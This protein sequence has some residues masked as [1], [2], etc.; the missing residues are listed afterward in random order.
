VGAY[1]FTD[2]A[3]RDLESICDSIAINNPDAASNLFD[4]IREQCL[5]VAKFPYSG[6]NYAQIKPNLRGFIVKSY[7]VFYSIEGENI[8][9]IRVISGYRDLVDIFRSN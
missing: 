1:S 2:N 4:D 8:L 7:I 6:K 5:R 3:I 9:M